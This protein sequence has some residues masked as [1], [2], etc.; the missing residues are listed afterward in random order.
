MNK[1][2]RELNLL[3]SSLTL[4]ILEDQRL[5]TTKDCEAYAHLAEIISN[6][7]EII[8]VMLDG[9]ENRGLLN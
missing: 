3:L 8:T 9:V 4:S 7:D 5:K 2:L 1:N 6:V